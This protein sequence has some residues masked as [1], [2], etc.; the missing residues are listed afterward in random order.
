VA[1][2]KRLSEKVAPLILGAESV[3]SNE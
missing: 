3:A 2:L 1:A